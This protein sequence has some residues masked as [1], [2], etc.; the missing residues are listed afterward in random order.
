MDDVADASWITDDEVMEGFCRWLKGYQ[1][2]LKADNPAAGPGQ[3]ARLAW[4]K[5]SELDENEKNRYEALANGSERIGF[6]RWLDSFSAPSKADQPKGNEAS[7]AEREDVG[8]QLKR[9]GDAEAVEVVGGEGPNA[10][11]SKEN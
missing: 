11:L 2:Q 6:F 4:K 8:N 5:W 1:Y 9:R 7:S 3:L 10:K